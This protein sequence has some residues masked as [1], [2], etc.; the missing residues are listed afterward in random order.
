MSGLSKIERRDGLVSKE[1]REGVVGSGGCRKARKQPVIEGAMQAVGGNVMQVR[2]CVTK[3]LK[4]AIWVWVNRG[5]I[6]ERRT[7]E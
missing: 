5:V 1:G 2:V 3:R 6:T 4:C 7:N